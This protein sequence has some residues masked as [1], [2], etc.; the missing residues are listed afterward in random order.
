MKS[1][2]QSILGGRVGG[3]FRYAT[4]ATQPPPPYRD[5]QGSKAAF[6]ICGL[7]MSLHASTHLHLRAVQV[8][9]SLGS[10]RRGYSTNGYSYK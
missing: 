9:L 1:K 4:N 3:G 2:F 8:S 5:H 7:D 10:A 6:V